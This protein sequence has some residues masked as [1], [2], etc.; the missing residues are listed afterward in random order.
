MPRLPSLLLPLARRLGLA[1]GILLRPTA[2]QRPQR[3]LELFSYE[4]CA[5]CRRVRA[6]L[7]ELDLDY[8]HRSCPVG[9][10]RNRDVVAA[11]GAPVRVP[12]LVDPNTAVEMGEAGAIV[13]YLERRYG[14]ARVD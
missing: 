1:R 2:G 10:R 13:D 4:G 6:T 5:S 11:R 12:Y 9:A 7:T 8:L 3:P 14:V